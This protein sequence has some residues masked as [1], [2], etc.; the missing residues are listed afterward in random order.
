MV[1]LFTTLHY[2]SFLVVIL[3]KDS[4]EIIQLEAGIVIPILKADYE[5]YK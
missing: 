3:L 1:N 4:L 5:V 2:S